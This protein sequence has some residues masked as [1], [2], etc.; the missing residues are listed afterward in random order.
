MFIDERRKTKDERLSI[1]LFFA[2]LVALLL[3]ACTDY[4]AE[5]EESFGALE[6]IGEEFVSSDA[7]HHGGVSGSGDGVTSSA[8]SGTSVSGKSSSS[9]AGTSASGKPSSSGEGVSATDK[10]SS[11]VEGTSATDNPSSFS[12]EESSSAMSSSGVRVEVLYNSMEVPESY[13]VVDIGSLTWMVENLSI[14]YVGGISPKDLGP[15]SGWLYKRRDA[16]TACSQYTGWRLPSKADWDYLTT[17]VGEGEGKK[18]KSE[19]WY[20]GDNEYGFNVVPVGYSKDGKTISY[21]KTCFWTSSLSTTETTGIIKC[22][23]SDS[24]RLVEDDKADTND[25]YSVRCVKGKLPPS[26]YV[27]SSASV[28]PSSSFSVSRNKETILG[29]E[30]DVVEIGTDE[31]NKS[32]KWMAANLLYWN[33]FSS[34]ERTCYNYIE[35][36]DKN[37]SICKEYGRYYDKSEASSIDNISDNCWVLPTADQFD[38]LIGMIGGTGN[39]QKLF[40]TKLEDGTNESGFD[41]ISAGYYDS[42][43]GLFTYKTGDTYLLYKNCFWVRNE[44]ADEL[45]GFCFF[46]GADEMWSAQEPITDR[47]IPVRLIY[48]KT[49]CNH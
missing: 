38:T 43:N 3:T 25:Y 9:G 34:T 44:K 42:S 21:E 7:G 12:V 28:E 47:R 31:G 45:S 41:I 16:K 48:D 30:Y 46:F 39:L 17:V 15:L 27:N 14:N 1:A 37:D 24:T 2:F 32:Q 35:Y 26:D 40:S 23:Y 6:Y 8:I 18:L 19:G 10:S 4:Q 20:S 11:S 49:H 29:T 13:K 22:F 5:F 36:E 33:D